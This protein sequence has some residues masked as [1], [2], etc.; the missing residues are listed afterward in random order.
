M[1]RA[2]TLRVTLAICIRCSDLFCRLRGDHKPWCRKCRAVMDTS[3]VI[4]QVHGVDV[5]PKSHKKP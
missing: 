1:K 5:T 4:A 2:A 3:R